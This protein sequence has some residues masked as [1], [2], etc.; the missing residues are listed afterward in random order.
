[1]KGSI[2]QRGSASWELLVYVGTD[3][4]IGKRRWATRT[5]RGERADAER[6]LGAL[7]AQ[8]N[9]A[10][11]VGARTT[12]SGLLDQWLARGSASWAPTT[13]RNVRSIVDSYLVGR[14]GDVPLGDG[15]RRHGRRS[16]HRLGVDGRGDGEPLRIGMVRRVH[17]VLHAALAQA[18]RRGWVFDN[19]AAHAGPPRAET[20][21]MHPPTAAEVAVLLDLVG[22]T[23]RVFALFLTLSGDHG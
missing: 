4:V 11:A 13:V 10:P 23:D 2:R 1:M 20:A 8:A 12:V 15:D 22:R 14:I 21:E 19:V 16:L 9:L 6:A 3:R 5:V 7:A 18:V 17:S